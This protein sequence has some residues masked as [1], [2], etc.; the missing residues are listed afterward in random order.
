[1]APDEGAALKLRAED[2]E[3]LAVISACLQDALVAVRDLAYEPEERS[4]LFVANRF[5]W[6]NGLRPAPGETPLERVLCGITF[7]GVTAAS[8]SGF[9]RTNDGRI[10]SLLAIR[11]EDGAVHLEFSG[12]AVIRLDVARIR[13]HVRDLGDPWPTPWQPRHDL[14]EAS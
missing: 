2:A 13:C 11:S 5:R 8:Y 3:D 10:L 6:E 7:S 4:F 14:D 1:M 12:G 9:R